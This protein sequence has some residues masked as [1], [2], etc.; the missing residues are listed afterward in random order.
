MN[1]QE[2]TSVRGTYVLWLEH[3]EAL[4]DALE[5]DEGQE[6]EGHGQQD[7]RHLVLLPQRALLGLVSTA[8]TH[9][10]V[11]GCRSCLEMIIITEQDDVNY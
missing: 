3:E 2:D 11:D 9:R 4:G 8:L 5:G 10:P 6:G 7:L 1:M